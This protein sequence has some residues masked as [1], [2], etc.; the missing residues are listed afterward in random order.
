ME[1]ISE[2][3]SRDREWITWN[4]VTTVQLSMNE[5]SQF[6]LDV[7][8]L[9]SSF[10]SQSNSNL[11]RN[12]TSAVTFEADIVRSLSVSAKRAVV[13]YVSANKSSLKVLLIILMSLFWWHGQNFCWLKFAIHYRLKS[14]EV[15]T[16]GRS[17][18]EPLIWCI[19]C[20]WIAF[21]PIHFHN[22][23]TTL[24]K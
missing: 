20:R 22:F 23:F 4:H 8:N 11:V 1:W 13:E 19:D 5:W 3:I 14:F 10:S 18:L 6:A 12:S 2:K 9:P 17:E 16:W 21:C 15:S 24:W 7:A